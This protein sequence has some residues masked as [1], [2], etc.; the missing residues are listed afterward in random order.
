MQQFLHGLRRGLGF[1]T[2]IAVVIGV[3]C[4]GESATEHLLAQIQQ[5]GGSGSS[6]GINAPLPAG[7]NL[8]GKV[9]I[10]QSTPGT[11]NKV[12]IGT[13]GTIALNAAIPT[14]TNI[15]GFVRVLPAGCTQ[16]TRFTSD[17]VGVATSAGTSVT[18]TT[19]CVT[20]AYV[21]NISNAAVTFRI[22][23]KTGT[24]VIWLG[25]NADFS[26]PANSNVGLPMLAGIVMTGGV[27][28]IAGTGA[29]LNF[30]VE[31]YQ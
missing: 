31:G 12:S 7:T 15:I 30:H 27:T 25:G 24:P 22:A 10:D 19:T 18:S 26:I 4:L 11:T 3:L 2:S 14:G 23:D 9:G 20:Q 17:T 5:S 8:I 28:A 1:V 16:T 29:S 13:D 21:N 6:V